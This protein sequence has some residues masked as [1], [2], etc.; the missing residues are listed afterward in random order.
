MPFQNITIR[1]GG[2]RVTFI[3]A[4]KCVLRVAVADP[5]LI[6]HET[7]ASH[8]NINRV[9][10]KNVVIYIIIS[11]ESRGET[12]V[13]VNFFRDIRNRQAR[14]RNN[15]QLQLLLYPYSRRGYNYRGAHKPDRSTITSKIFI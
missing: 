3:A 8:R 4:I 1:Q 10:R 6:T 11:A 5:I 9:E 12:L 13:I 7:F 2:R 15:P 14:E